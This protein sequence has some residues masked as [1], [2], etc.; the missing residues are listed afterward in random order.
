MPITEFAPLRIKEITILI[1]I[2][3]AMAMAMTVAIALKIGYVVIPFTV[4]TT[5][6]R[7]T[8]V[9]RITKFIRYYTKEKNTT[10][11]EV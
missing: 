5:K 11:V 2:M 6:G 10:K 8:D 3:M 1:I 9:R 7:R 4:A